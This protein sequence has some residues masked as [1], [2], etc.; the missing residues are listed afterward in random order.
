MIAG[1]ISPQNQP[2]LWF[3]CPGLDPADAHAMLL[4][5]A[6][7]R[8]GVLIDLDGENSDDDSTRESHDNVEQ[9]HDHTAT[10]DNTNQSHDLKAAN[11]NTRQTQDLG[12]D[13][14]LANQME[15]NL[16]EFEGGERHWQPQP[17]L[18]PTDTSY[19]QQSQ[20]LF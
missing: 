7:P 2:A 6:E 8:T 19:P 5:P 15:R 14:T 12:G 4:Q 10:D 20:E 13:R 11:D 18:S 16:L 1:F 17:S 9:S 3:V